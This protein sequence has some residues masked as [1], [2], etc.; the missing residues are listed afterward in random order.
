MVCVYIKRILRTKIRTKSH[1]MVRTLYWIFHVEN[2]IVKKVLLL[3]LFPCRSSDLPLAVN[4]SRPKRP[5]LQTVKFTVIH[6]ARLQNAHFFWWDCEQFSQPKGQDLQQT[7][8][9]AEYYSSPH[10]I[11]S[12]SLRFF[13]FSCFS[14]VCEEVWAARDCSSM[15]ALSP[16]RSRVCRTP[17]L[18]IQCYTPGLRPGAASKH[19]CSFVRSLQTGRTFFLSLTVRVDREY[20]DIYII[21]LNISLPPRESGESYSCCHYTFS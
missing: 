18:P 15:R 11:S 21:L 17:G 6:R 1:Y 2:N 13:F 5:T 4:S 7:W 12:T 16:K 19:V 20:I 10:V 3:L 14:T 9:P 8:S